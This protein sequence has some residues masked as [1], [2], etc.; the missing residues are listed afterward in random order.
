[1]QIK[2]VQKTSLTE[3]IM[4]QIVEQIHTN[5]LKPRERLPNE[6]TMAEMFGVTRNSVREAIRALSVLGLITIKPG[7]GNYV[8]EKNLELP[9]ETIAWLYHE[10][11][12]KFDEI[13]AARRLIET[14]VYLECFRHLTEEVMAGIRSRYQAARQYHLQQE[15]FSA[16]DYCS[17]L[18]DL[19]LYVGQNC[20]NDIYNK[21]MQTIVTLRRESA[22]KISRLSEARDRGIE[23]RGHI[24][25]AME[26]GDEARLGRALK[27]FYKRAFF[28]SSNTK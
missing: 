17:L 12:S 4:E 28:T 1:M 14:E 13:Y 5:Q 26:S 3:Q 9:Q 7:S 20:Q 22:I 25:E 24:I 15:N 21:F 10:E 6:R 8:N 11:T 19:D 27:T 18:D 23:D 2:A 16:E